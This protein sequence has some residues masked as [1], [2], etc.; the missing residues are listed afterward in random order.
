MHKILKKI[1]T[2]ISSLYWSLKIKKTFKLDGFRIL[3][4]DTISN[5]N[6]IFFGK[7]VNIGSRAILN[8]QNENNS[9][10]LRIG[11]RCKI[12]RDV[13]INAY[14]NVRIGENV[15]IS[16]RVHI[17]DASHN[18][19]KN[20]A[21]LDQGADFYGAVTIEN[22]V[23]IGINA[24]ILPNVKIGE[25][26]IVAANCVVNIDVPKNSIAVGVPARILNK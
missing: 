23:W 18:Y 15:L 7:N 26:S 4:V 20:E 17:S 6:Q 12:G 24:V 19:K 14:R 9:I 8:C 5:P 25:N 16:D 1:L 3:N 13:Q 2:F 10:A 22:G 21:I 11:D